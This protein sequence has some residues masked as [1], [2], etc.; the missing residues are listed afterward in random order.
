M[1]SARGQVVGDLIGIAHVATGEL[2]TAFLT[3]CLVLVSASPESGWRPRALRG[4]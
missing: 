3:V 1:K 4:P 2:L